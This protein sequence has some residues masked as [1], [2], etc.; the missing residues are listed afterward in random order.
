[1]VTADCLTWGSNSI[2]FEAEAGRAYYLVVDGYDE[3]AGPFGAQFECSDEGSNGG[4]DD[5]FN[6]F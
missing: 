4:G 6:P 3:D 1:M 5:T 2:E